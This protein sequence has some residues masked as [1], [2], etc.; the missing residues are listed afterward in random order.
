MANNQYST[1][2]A[3]RIV[4]DQEPITYRLLSRELKVHTALAKRYLYAFHTSSRSLYPDKVHATYLISGQKRPIP[5]ISGDVLMSDVSSPPST[6]PDTDVT[7][8]DEIVQT[9]FELVPEEELEDAKSSFRKIDYVHVYSLE[10]TR[11]PE[12]FIT[13]A[14]CGRRVRDIDLREDPEA[15]SKTYGTIL[16]P[17]AKR[18][19]GQ[20]GQFAS[21]QPNPPATNVQTKSKAPLPKSEMKQERALAEK[22]RPVSEPSASTS[23]FALGSKNTSKNHRGRPTT[24]EDEPSSNTIK[25]EIEKLE[26]RDKKSASPFTKSVSARSD[27]T[28]VK[29][30][31]K[32]GSSTPQSSSQVSQELQSMFSSS[33][34]ENEDKEEQKPIKAENETPKDVIGAIHDSF[35]SDDIDLSIDKTPVNLKEEEI[36]S[37]DIEMGPAPP[38]EEAGTELVEQSLKKRPHGRSR[39]KITKEIHIK[40]AN[41]FLT[42]KYEDVWESYSELSDEETISASRPVSAPSS[43]PMKKGSTVART[44]KDKDAAGKKDNGAK[45]KQAGGGQ[46]SLMSFWKK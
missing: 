32:S 16:E 5:A 44:P 46:S 1:F 14:E 45:K 33:E 43:A 7:H 20:P 30:Q 25:K 15:I 19:N 18:Q 41:G 40:D 6:L 11:L 34:D 29:T 26:S 8:D 9:I 38:L 4:H 21:A 10:P 12:D 3:T 17:V 36:K 27:I 39:R 13:L 35:I 31:K 42:T 28:R 22:Q 24:T 37:E 2:L 23:L